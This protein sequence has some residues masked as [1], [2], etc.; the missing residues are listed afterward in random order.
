MRV[1]WMTDIVAALNHVHTL[2]GGVHGDVSSANVLVSDD[3]AKQQCSWISGVG[4]LAAAYLRRQETTSSVSSRRLIV[5]AGRRNYRQL[6]RRHVF[7]QLAKDV[8]Q[9]D[10]GVGGR[11]RSRR[12]GA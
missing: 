6:L 4:E 7:G 10:L 8:R 3:D 2:T 1:K 12:E 9:R 11:T 5:T